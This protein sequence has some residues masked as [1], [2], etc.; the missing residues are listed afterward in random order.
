M[1]MGLYSFRLP[2]QLP[3]TTQ[4]SLHLSGSGWLWHLH[5]QHTSTAISTYL[6]RMKKRRKMGKHY[7][8]YSKQCSMF[9]LSSLGLVSWSRTITVHQPYYLGL[10]QVIP[11]LLSVPKATL[12]P[13]QTSQPQSSQSPGG[14]SC[15]VSG[16]RWSYPGTGTRTPLFVKAPVIVTPHLLP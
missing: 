11:W 3:L 6:D 8:N 7:T 5:C 12:A 14:S 10:D 9:N 2:W 15:S 4:L 13:S 16:V 1:V